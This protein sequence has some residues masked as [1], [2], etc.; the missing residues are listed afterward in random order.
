M[1]VLR[2]A[3]AHAEGG[4]PLVPVRDLSFSAERQI[5]DG[6]VGEFQVRHR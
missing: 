2:R 5:T 4:Q 1:T 3:D 6:D